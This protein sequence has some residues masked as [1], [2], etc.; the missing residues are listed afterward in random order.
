MT[1]VA[2]LANMDEAA[3]DGWLVPSNAIRDRGDGSHGDGRSPTASR[4]PF[5]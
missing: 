4:R 1:A 3:A 2:T 5:R